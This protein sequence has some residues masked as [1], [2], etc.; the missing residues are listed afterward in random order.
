[1]CYWIKKRIKEYINQHFSSEND[2]NFL[3]INLSCYSFLEKSHMGKP[4]NC[5]SNKIHNRREKNEL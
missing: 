3:T 1:M 4:N 2:K 5:M